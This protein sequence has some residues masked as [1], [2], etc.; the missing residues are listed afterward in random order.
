MS[1][2]DNLTYIQLEKKLT[3]AIKESKTYK[4]NLQNPTKS[5]KIDKSIIDAIDNR[6]QIL[7]KYIMSARDEEEQKPNI[8]RDLLTARKEVRDKIQDA[9]SRYNHKALK[10]A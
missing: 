3:E 1:L 7:R 4:T 8:E 2:D 5:D 6:N 9:K 10:T